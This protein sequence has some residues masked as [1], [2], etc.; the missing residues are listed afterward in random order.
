MSPHGAIGGYH[1][2]FGVGAVIVAMAALSALLIRDSD[3]AS[4]MQSRAPDADPVPV[5]ADG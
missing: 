3:A 5:V 4:T 1:L 2:A